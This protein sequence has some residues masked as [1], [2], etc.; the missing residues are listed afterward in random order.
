MDPDHD[1]LEFVG[2]CIADLN[3][4]G[5][6]WISTVQDSPYLNPQVGATLENDCKEEEEFKKEA[7]LET[8]SDI[9]GSSDSSVD[10]KEKED[11]RPS[12]HLKLRKKILGSP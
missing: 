10:R 6:A 12:L 3:V 8:L 1:G 2:A 11:I 7:S 4:N 9:L 5:A